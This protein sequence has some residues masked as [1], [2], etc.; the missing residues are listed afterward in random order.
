MGRKQALT[1]SQVPSV[2]PGDSKLISQEPRRANE[3][4]VECFTGS[5]PLNQGHVSKETLTPVGGA[6]LRP[7]TTGMEVV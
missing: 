3:A 4:E 7:L 2:L 5:F 1:A 6:I